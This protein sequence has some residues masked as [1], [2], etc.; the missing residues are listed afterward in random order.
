MPEKRRALPAKA[1]DTGIGGVAGLFKGLDIAGPQIKGQVQ[2]GAAYAAVRK[3]TAFELA[4]PLCEG[5]GKKGVFSQAH[6]QLRRE[7]SDIV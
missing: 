6:L 3:G 2:Q 1:Q 5:G 7:V 4:D